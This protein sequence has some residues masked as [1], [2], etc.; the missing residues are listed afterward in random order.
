MEPEPPITQKDQAA[1][2]RCPTC[3]SLVHPEAKKCRHCGEVLVKPPRSRVD[4]TLKKVVLYVGLATTFLSLFYALREGYYFVQARQEQRAAIASFQGAAEYFERLDNLD[5]AEAILK[6]ALAL[7]PN[8]LKLQRRRFLLRAHSVL[9][10]LESIGGPEE[11]QETISALTLDGFRLLQIQ[12]S[13]ADRARV[14]TM[15]G[16]LLP[17]DYNWKDRSRITELFEEAHRLAPDDAEV[18]FRY[19]YWLVSDAEEPEKGYGYIR[20][21]TEI[22][23]ENAFYWAELGKQLLKE[24]AYR[25]ALTPL[26]MALHLLPEQHERQRILE[27][28]GAAYLLG[29]LLLQADEQQDIAG[30]DFLG[31]T[32]GERRDILREVLGVK[33]L[34]RNFSYLA[35]RFYQ[36]DGDTANALKAIRSSLVYSDLSRIRGSDKPKYA[37]YADILETS[38]TDPELLQR[39]RTMLHSSESSQD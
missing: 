2:A 7:R 35:A 25:E 23:P 17:Q 6:Q 4:A 26:R 38:G 13:D 20:S 34:D 21:A 14:L 12:Q 19:G 18:N 29:K 24:M 3:K 15:L 5:Y 37:L 22:D 9:R 28:R 30:P 16:R 36:A 27:A 11:D 10:D 8:D 31:Q 39:L 33:T 32:M 1:E